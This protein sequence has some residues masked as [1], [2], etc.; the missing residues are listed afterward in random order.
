[1]RL[2]ETAREGDSVGGWVREGER[3]REGE[4]ERGIGRR[5]ETEGRK[6][7]IC[8]GANLAP[9]RSS[10]AASRALAPSPA[11]SRPNLKI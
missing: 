8:R 5:G 1:M 9:R 7:N 2:G 10:R 6:G 11:Q 4:K 3:E